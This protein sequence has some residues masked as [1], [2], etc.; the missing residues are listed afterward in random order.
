[1]PGLSK[2]CST[3]SDRQDARQIAGKKRAEGVLTTQITGFQRRIRSASGRDPRRC[4]CAR[5]RSRSDLERQAAEL[6]ACATDLQRR[7]R[8]ARAA[9]RAA[10]RAASARSPTGSWRS[11]RTTSPT[12]VTVVLEPT[13]STDLLD[14]ADFLPRISDQDQPH[15]HAVRDLKKQVD[16]RRRRSS[17]ARAR[18]RADATERDPARGATR[19]PPSKHAIV[20]RQSDLVP[21]RSATG[22][23]AIR[24]RDRERTA[25]RPRGPP[26]SAPGAAAR[27]PAL[28][29]RRAGRRRPIRSSAARAT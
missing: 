23:R 10:G 9:A 22:A 19:S 3:Q 17:R 13:A 14:R 8:P 15:R 7:A 29:R 21:A 26:D 4:S 6:S 16:R 2:S 12:C 5:T 18:R 11:T 24:A 25:A 28:G 20:A 1:M 27:S